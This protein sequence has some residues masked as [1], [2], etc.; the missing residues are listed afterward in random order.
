MMRRNALLAF[1][2]R[3]DYTHEVCIMI[4]GER[5]YETERIGEK[6]RGGRICF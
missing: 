2:E 1:E 4:I 6:I 3:L 5:V